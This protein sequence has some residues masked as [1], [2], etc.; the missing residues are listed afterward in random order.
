MRTIAEIKEQKELSKIRERDGDAAFFRGTLLYEAILLIS[1]Q[2][3][4]INIFR[5]LKWIC[6]SMLSSYVI[7]L[8]YAELF[9]RLDHQ[10]YYC[11]IQ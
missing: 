10:G 2:Y 1:I 7:F 6:R 9:F 3:Y 11:D 8:F 4:P 5:L